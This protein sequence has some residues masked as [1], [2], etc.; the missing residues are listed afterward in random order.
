MFSYNFPQ[1]LMFFYIYCLVGWIIE[2]TI[3]SVESRKLVNRGFLR[4]PYLPIYGFGALTILFVTLPFSDNPAMVYLS[5]LIG[6]TIL[7]YITGA[8]METFLKTKYWDYSNQKFNYK[9]RICL[10]SSLFWGFLSLLLTYVL[11]KPIEKAVLSLYEVNL[12]AFSI[13]LV[14]VSFLF[15]SDMVYAFKT[16]LDVN[17]LLAK[18]TKIK[19]EMSQIKKQIEE[20]TENS[21][22]TAKLREKLQ[23][24]K[25]E[26][27]VTMDKIGFFRTNLIKAHPTARSI[28][29]NE[30]LLEVREKINQRK[31]Q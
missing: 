2:S 14:S 20:K 13:V 18:I 6:T 3:V 27:S 19:E 28:K 26:H 24:L 7:E 11:H 21:E 1:W 30:A 10:T 22:I 5:G 23:L 15:L 25:N 8:L 4:G 12:V 16:A 9:G 29:F 31:K 17:K